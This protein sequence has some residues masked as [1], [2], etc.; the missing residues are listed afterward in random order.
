M[1]NRIE[2]AMI[3]TLVIELWKFFNTMHSIAW[4]KD[5]FLGKDI[6]S[7]QIGFQTLALNKQ[8]LDYLYKASLL[9]Q[10]R[11]EEIN[12][13]LLN[14][15]PN[16]VGSWNYMFKKNQEQIKTAIDEN[17]FKAE[18]YLSPDKNIYENM[19]FAKAETKQENVNVTVD[20]LSD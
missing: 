8:T 18:L 1:D 9:T 5:F 20:N 7:K 12:E 6:K 10:E 14:N 15:I 19:P 4:I 3:H 13:P 11:A 17:F 2:D 16:L